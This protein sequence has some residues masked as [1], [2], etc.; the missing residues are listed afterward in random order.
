MSV[1]RV[2]ADTRGD[3]DSGDDC[4]DPTG[5]LQRREKYQGDR[6]DAR[7]LAEHRA[8]GAPDQRDRVSL[9]ALYPKLGRVQE[10]LTALLTAR[11]SQSRRE[12]LTLMR[13]WELLREDGYTGSYDAV[14]RYARRWRRAQGH[15]DTAYVP[16]TFDPGEA[17]QFDWSHEIV[18]L[19]GVTTTVKVAHMRLCH[20][21]MPF[22]RAY[23]RETQ[24]MVFDAHTRAFAFFRGACGRGIYDNMKTAVDAVFVGKARQFK[25]CAAVQSLPGGTGGLYARRG[26]GEGPSRKPG[27]ASD[28]SR[29]GCG[30]RATSSSMPGCSISVWRRRDGRPT[31]ITRS[32]RSLRCSRR[33]V[34]LTDSVPAPSMG[35][36]SRSPRCPRRASRG[37]TTTATASWPARSGGPW[38]STPTPSGS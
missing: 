1:G 16:L 3:A 33:S 34:P 8:E 29:R 25:L 14:R 7:R 10:R 32:A 20:S 37:S 13:M 21:R 19:G 38:R 11:L 28:G 26:L 18:V 35:A 22:V 9:R 15:A 30:L 5:S 2:S 23:P 27:S 24:E 36:A 4:K 31:P 6:A 12:R 17:Y